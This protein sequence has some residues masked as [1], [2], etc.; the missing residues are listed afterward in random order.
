[1]VKLVEEKS[2]SNSEQFD[3]RSQLAD[4]FKDSPLSP[5]D[6]MFNLGMYV[7]SSLLV[8]FLVM[9]DLY[10]RIKNIPGSLL[11]FG[12]WWGQNLVLMENLRAI[13]E[14]FNKQRVIV[15]FD[16]FTG[17]ENFSEKDKQSKVYQDKSYKTLADYK[18]YLAQ[19]L[20]AHEGSNAF[21]HIRG[22]HKL[23][24]GDV[25]KTAPKYFD[26]HPETIV[27]LAYFDI[28]IYK[29]TKAAL[30]AIKPHLVS[31][32]V[33]LL[34]QLTWQGGAGEAIAFKEVFSNV[35]F[36]IEKCQIYP[37]KAIVTIK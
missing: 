4:L 10:E 11:E 5:D 32:S 30:E 34:D 35:S 29:P 20:E 21:G 16:T 7:R 24:A 22:N 14:P 8:K 19:L 23:I 36:R 6:I 28:G 17:Y 33:I 15:G 9:N 37:S 2:A 3:F 1:M 18:S 25:T 26:D 31:G 27:A 12:V 13:H